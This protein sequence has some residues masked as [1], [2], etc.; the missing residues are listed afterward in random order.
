M[1]NKLNENINNALEHLDKCIKDIRFRI[2]EGK[3]IFVECAREHKHIFGTIEIIA[4]KEKE[5]ND[6]AEHIKNNEVR[7]IDEEN[8]LNQAYEELNTLHKNKDMILKR[9][10]LFKGQLSTKIDLFQKE[11]D[12]LIVVGTT[13]G[14][15]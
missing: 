11:L 9:F 12:D 3:A 4:A 10:I 6:M 8:K 13:F 5:I 1:F 15:F 2:I 14:K 7:I